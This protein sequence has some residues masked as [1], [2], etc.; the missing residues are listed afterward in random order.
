VSPT[1]IV[2]AIAC[3]TAVARADAPQ[4]WAVGVTA[5]QRARAKQLLDAGNARMLDHDYAAALDQF[6]AGI[7][8]WDH[9]AIRFNI[10]RCLI[11]LD[12]PV[13]ASE[14]LELALKYGAAP[15]E[16]AVYAEALN[17]Q[18]LLANQISD[19]EVTC[20]QDHV[21]VSLDGRS[22]VACPGSAQRR[23]AP[24]QHQIVGTGPGL[25]TKTID[26]VLLGGKRQRVAVTLASPGEARIVR[27][28]NQWLPWAVFGSGFA[29]VGAGALLEYHAST[30]MDRYDRAVT[31]D[32]VNTSCG[33]SQLAVDVGLEHSAQAFNR[34]AI[35]VF[36]TGG[37]AIA[38]GTVMLYLNRGH[39]GYS[40]AY[41]PRDGG[42]TINVTGRF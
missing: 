4:P 33:S 2:L 22:I 28:W 40:A 15:L 1:W 17:Y 18:K 35:G 21:K 13:E 37:L 6:R 7:A 8:V 25:S 16:D 20:T 29:I 34:I 36:A 39:P 24:G 38:T 26:L 23:V 30:E 12:R 42:G 41:E 14:N 11:Q 9:P 31:R 10:V 3:V 5:E 32:C 19:V 27:R